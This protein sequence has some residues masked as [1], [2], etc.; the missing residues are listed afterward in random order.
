MKPSAN[1]RRS[2][3]SPAPPV[4]IRSLMGQ[5]PSYWPRNVFAGSIIWEFF[6]AACSSGVVIA[7]TEVGA[8]KETLEFVLILRYRDE[9][10]NDYQRVLLELLT[11]LGFG[12]IS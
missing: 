2:P 12:P 10:V 1:A 11:L 6:S 9:S 4:A 3:D 5:N 7:S 8:P